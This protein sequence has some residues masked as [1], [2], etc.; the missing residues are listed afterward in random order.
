[1]LRTIGN[2]SYVDPALMLPG[3]F[4]FVALIGIVVADNI[5]TSAYK[6]L[7]ITVPGKKFWT[8]VLIISI[9]ILGIRMFQKFF[10]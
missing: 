4:I 7:F 1:M 5:T 9:L 10:H 2:A 8:I 3:F 6:G